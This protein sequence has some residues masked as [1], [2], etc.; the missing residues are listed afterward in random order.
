[1]L[2]SVKNFYF[3]KMIRINRISRLPRNLSFAAG[4][5]AV[6]CGLLLIA[7]VSGTAAK[8]QQSLRIAAVV[9][10]EIISV[11]DLETR[12][13]LLLV[14]TNQQNTQESRR[15]IAP[16]VLRSL[17]DE[18]LKLQEAKR[19]GIKIDN[20]E[21]NASYALIEK[22]NKMPKG[23]LDKV[24]ARNGIPKTAMTDQIRADIAWVRTV[25]QRAS[26]QPPIS[27]EQVDEKLAEIE[28]NKGKPEM[29]VAE[30][31]LAVDSPK[32]ATEAGSQAVRLLEN[33]KN[34]APFPA[35]AQNFSQ[36][37]SAAIGGNLGWIKQGQ[38][39]Q[40]LDAALA[41][42]QPG[43]ISEPIR[44]NAGYYILFLRKR[45]AD[46]GMEG[47]DDVYVTLKQL[48]FPVPANAPA[49]AVANKTAAAN[50]ARARAATCGDMDKLALETASPMSGSLGRVKTSA[51]PDQIRQA[52]ENLK[53]STASQPVRTSDGMVVLMVCKREGATNDTLKVRI[54]RMLR[55]K[56]HDLLARRYLRDMRRTALVDI[57][58]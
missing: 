15:R 41:S 42:M 5:R 7:L 13:A 37:A 14:S 53:V 4:L 43:Q 8:A 49:D 48:F 3:R 51:L 57:R 29:L 11:Y 9:N 30:I 10:D 33:L 19:L 27:E 44:T 16:Q 6:F 40:K 12:T 2:F 23:G 55:E 18:K 21:V 45:R 46:P 56:R 32:K 47:L 22:Q 31:F 1:M 54:R 35:L 26:L 52:V 28:S 50:A 58:L 34:G 36:S 17:I 24:L 39:G 20:R 38:L 25:V